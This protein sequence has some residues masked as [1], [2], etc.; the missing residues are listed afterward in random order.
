MEKKN[1]KRR[2]KAIII[3][4]DGATFDIIEPLVAQ[5][6]LPNIASLMENGVWGK[7]ESSTPPLTPVAWTSIST[8][9]NPGT[10]GIYDIM[11]YRPDEHKMCLIN[12]TMR[13]VKPLWSILS[14]R[15]NQVGILNVPVTYPPDTVNGFVI[16]GMFTPENL[17]DFMYPSELKSELEN[18]FGRYI[19]ECDQIDNPAYYLKLIHKMIKQREEV[20]LHLMNH[21]NTDFFF[22]VF[23]ASDRAQHFYWKYMNPSHPEHH[24]YKDSIAKVYERMDQAL[25]RILGK[26]GDDAYVMMVSDHGFGPLKSA[27]FLNNWLIKKGYLHLKQ[28]PAIALNRKINSRYKTEVIRFLKKITPIS[29]WNKLKPDFV[30]KSRKEDNLFLSLI[31]WEKTVAFSEGAGGGIYIN[32]NTV[33]PEQYEGVINEIIDGL[34]DLSEQEGKKI[35]KRVF[36]KKDIFSGNFTAN[37]PDLTIICNGGYHIVV[38]SELLFLNKKYEDSLFMPHRWSGRHEQHG[39][40]LVK[41]PGIR[42]KMEIKGARVIDIAPTVLYL[43]NEKIPEKMEGNLLEAAVVKEHILN[44]PVQYTT[45]IIIQEKE[46]MNLSEEEE[47][48]I[49]ERLKNLGYI[50]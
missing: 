30:A 2:L 37:A 13:K 1:H 3:G 47:K 49:A 40:F 39:I 24:K 8:G 21:Y 31:D 45:D 11:V 43:M 6:R 48:E 44:E 41:G 4:W 36:L 7:L 12:S 10:H 42:K 38:P 29:I 33:K 32:P 46:E 20:T 9:V 15:G 28:D 22:V 35:I 50:E 18:K 34:S 25:G 26:A 17:S 14:D 19:V 5:G 23:I 27:F 16:P